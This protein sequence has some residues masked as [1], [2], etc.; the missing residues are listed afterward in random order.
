MKSL[1]LISVIFATSVSFAKAETCETKAAEI[2]TS[3]KQIMGEDTENLRLQTHVTIGGGSSGR[4]IIAV[5]SATDRYFIEFQKIN[6]DCVEV[7]DV[8]LR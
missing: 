3:I 2:V 5:N 7:I 6:G 1:I 8:R 4:E